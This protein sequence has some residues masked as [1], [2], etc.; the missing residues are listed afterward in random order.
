MFKEKKYTIIKSA[1]SKELS[2]FVYNYF[3]LKRKVA[4]TYFDLKFISPFTEFFGVWNDKQVP[5]TYSHYGDIAM[6]TLL[7][8]LLPLMKEKTELNLIP[9]YAYAR[10]YKKGDIL[11]RHKDR[12]SCE[13]STTLN[14]GGDVWSIY[15]SPNENVGIAESDGGKKGITTSSNA[16]GIKVDLEPGDMLI[17]SG[18]ILEH[19]REPF[20]GEN[21]GQ[22]FL[23]YN[24]VDT[25]GDK[26]IYD[27]RPHLGLVS[28]F[29]R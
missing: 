4:R 26:N 20:E 3:L 23:H 1:I 27:G 22:V 6:E 16:K 15:L 5:E 10:I 17:Y 29:R 9:T 2:D 25:Q 14:L 7:E 11:K 24:N 28:G 13:I 12:P 8:K 21:C 18:C 19:W